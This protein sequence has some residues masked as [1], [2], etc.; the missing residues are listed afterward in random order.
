MIKEE[1]DSE[2]IAYDLETEAGT[3]L[4]GGFE[5]GLMCKN[6]DSCYV[7]F[8]I[9]P[10]DFSTEIE[11]MRELFRL[12]VECAKYCTNSFKPPIELEFEKYMFPLILFAKKKYAYLEWTEPEAPHPNVEFKGIQV[13][14][15]DTCDYVKEKCIQVYNI[16]MAERNKEE[17]F[18]K[19]YEYI[20]NAVKDLLNN[21]VDINKLVLSKQL[22]SRY[23]VRKNNMTNEYHWTD[24]K[25]TQPH[26]K[27]AQNLKIKDAAN[28]PKPPDRVPF[29]FIEKKGALLQ[30][31]K[32][33]SPD[34]FEIEGSDLKL[35]S[36][37]YFDHQFK[38][39]IDNLFQFLTKNPDIIYKDLVRKKK[40][41]IIDQQEI[42]DS[43]FFKIKKKS[44]VSAEE[45]V[46]SENEE[47][48]SN[49]EDEYE[50]I[51]DDVSED[52]Y[53]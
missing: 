13:V 45:I 12:A 23:K 25:I 10:S 6:T 14:R 44:T 37:Y 38:S 48:V 36:L 9:E 30:C 47:S 1:V 8:P 39:S 53:S 31:D 5:N 27:L 15:R 35:D 18:K 42:S 50:F 11:Y 33:V 46:C 20:R 21:N 2:D 7:K 29:I 40:N 41:E 16:V 22:K 34:D 24:S 52:L 32:V 51:E 19:S 4:A 3:F 28:H 26:V 17:A 43:P 49:S